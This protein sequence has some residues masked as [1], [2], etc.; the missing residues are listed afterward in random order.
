MLWYQTHRAAYDGVWVGEVNLKPTR[1]G[2][3]RVVRM[4]PSTL[5]SHRRSGRRSYNQDIIFSIS[6]VCTKC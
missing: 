2:S 3:A 1:G 4:A 6:S 5:S